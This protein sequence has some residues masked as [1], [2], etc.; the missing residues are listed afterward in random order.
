MADRKGDIFGAGHA[1]AIYTETKTWEHHFNSFISTELYFLI[2]I[3]RSYYKK[4][5]QSA[6]GIKKPLDTQVNPEQ[7]IE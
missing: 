7:L 6:L 4:S 3:C 5:L 2:S 1:L